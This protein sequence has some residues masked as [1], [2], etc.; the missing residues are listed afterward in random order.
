M[1]KTKKSKKKLVL[2]TLDLHDVPT[3]RALAEDI[4][5][6]LGEQKRTKAYLCGRMSWVKAF[7]FPLFDKEAKRLR[8]TGE[9]DIV[10]PAELDDPVIRAAALRSPDGDPSKSTHGHT[11]GDFLARD[12]KLIADEGIEA[13]ICLPEWWKSQG[14][15]VEV[16]IASLLGLPVLKASNLRPV[17]KDEWA[18]AYRFLLHR[19]GIANAI[20]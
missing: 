17:T 12:M 10:S 15:K 18:K 4:V 3:Q 16:F 7:N 19:M 13:I 20:R 14:A 2:T 6:A 8:A 1:G 9:W 11:W 5:E